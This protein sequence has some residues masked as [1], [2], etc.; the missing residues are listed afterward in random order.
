MKTNEI[1]TATVAACFSVTAQE[2][3]KQLIESGAK[4][5]GYGRKGDEQR[6]KALEE[7]YNGKLTVLLGDLTVEEDCQALVAQSLE[8]LDGAVDVHYHC[9]GVFSWN[10]WEDVPAKEV[11]RLFSA[12]F[13]TAWTL[14]REIFSAMKQTGTGSI[15][16]VSARDTIRNVSYGFGPYM[17]SKLALNGLVESLAAE[18][19]QYG[20]KVNA[21]LPTI[22]DTEVNRAAMPDIDHNDWVNPAQFAEIMIDLTQ[23]S[24]TNISGALIPVQGRMV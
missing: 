2:I 1:K 9:S 23:P 6:A 11:E 17:A 19:V 12:N 4:V 21:V 13:T 5:V 22:M 8:I 14:G 7:Q 18:G 24:K 15:M 16:F 10:S 20:V 3:I